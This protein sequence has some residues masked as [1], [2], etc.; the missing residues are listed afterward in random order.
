MPS[1]N[2]FE[3]IEQF[4][5]R[6]TREFDQ[7]GLAPLRDVAVDVTETDDE[8]VVAADL[9]GYEEDDLDITLEGRELTIRAER[10]EEAEETGDRYVR[11]ERSHQHLER[12]VTLPE[13][14][15]EEEASATYRNGVLLVTL[16]KEDTDGG[17]STSIDVA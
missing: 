15:V 6:M 7:A 5:Q 14:V 12:T 4:F 3:D 8:L 17:E 1:Q 16:P 2:P 13:A 9:P 10:R 11:R